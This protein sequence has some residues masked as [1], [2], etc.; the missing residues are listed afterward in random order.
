M[1][2]ISSIR[3][4]LFQSTP[5]L[6]VIRFYYFNKRERVTKTLVEKL[7]RTESKVKGKRKT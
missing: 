3:S 2:L 4:A 5:L 6:S 1:A 7:I